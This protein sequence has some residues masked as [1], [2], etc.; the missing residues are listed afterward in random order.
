MKKP[1]WGSGVRGPL[2][3]RSALAEVEGRS[4]A[5]AEGDFHALAVVGV[6]S[7]AG[8]G[9]DDGNGDRTAE[10]V[11][12]GAAAD[13]A[14][15]VELHLRASLGAL[16]DVFDHPA[17]Q[18][19]V[20]V[21]GVNSGRTRAIGEAGDVGAERGVLADGLADSCDVDLRTGDFEAPLADGADSSGGGVLDLEGVGG[22]GGALVGQ[23]NSR[24]TG[25][26]GDFQDSGRRGVGDHVVGRSSSQAGGKGAGTTG[27]CFG[28]D[29]AEFDGVANFEVQVASD[30]DFVVGCVD[31][32][33]TEGCCR[34][35]RGVVEGAGGA[36][37]DGG[38]R[39]YLE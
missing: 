36:R 3:V 29:N 4:G 26:G 39:K 10:G 38:H 12:H 34:G 30:G 1:R 28:V 17:G 22:N 14:V 31:G 19:G 21:G 16:D 7:Q 13:D 35:S 5:G 20:F 37:K 24:A 15:D 8:R 6:H 33:F 18:I 25:S 32:G 11:A 9:Q 23:V 27:A 2:R